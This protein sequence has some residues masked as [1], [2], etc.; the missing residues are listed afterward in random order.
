MKKVFE[1][2]AL[3]YLLFLVFVSLFSGLLVGRGVYADNSHRLFKYTPYQIDKSSFLSP[4]STK[5]L[6]GTDGVGRDILARLIKGTSNSFFISFIATV[7]SLLLGSFLGGLSG[8]LGGWFDFAFSRIF[9]LFYAL[10]MMFILILVSPIV[11]ANLLLFAIVLGLLGWLFVAR[12]VRGEVLKLKN[13]PF[14]EYAEVNGANYYYLFKKHFFPYI[15]PPLLPIAVFGFSG[16]LVA[17]SSLS[18]LGLGVRPPEPSWGQMIYDGFTYLDIAPWIYVPPSIL[19]FLTVL[20]LD[21]IGERFK[22]I[23]SRF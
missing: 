14:L 19:L 2:F 4:P 21:I 5:H 22:K 12:L 7:V 1:Y 8:Y 17:E 10:P 11:G 16:M 18:F 9:E 23:Y 6:L 20:S 15:L 3:F 13:T